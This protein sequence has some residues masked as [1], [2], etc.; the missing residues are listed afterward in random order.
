M[1]IVLNKTEFQH[2]FNKKNVPE[3][4]KNGKKYVN[5]SFEIVQFEL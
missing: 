3:N 2:I 5:K 4:K 1:Y